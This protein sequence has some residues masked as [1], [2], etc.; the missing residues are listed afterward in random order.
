MSLYTVPLDVLLWAFLAAYLVHIID[1]TLVGEGF[2]KIVQRWFWPQYH[3][4]MFFWFNVACILLVAACNALYDFLGGHWVIAALLWPFGFA[5][6][7]VTLH[8][9]WSI[10][11]GE[12]FS[13][14][15]TSPLYWI[16]VYFIYRYGYLGGQIE[17][18]DFLWGM[19][20]GTILI[21]G[22]LTFA[23]TYIFPALFRQKHGEN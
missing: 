13:G 4:R 2:T 5:V 1:E 19:A 15:L 17:R 8:L 12:Y 21:G 14:L 20:A 16:S 7:G 22:F 3:L 11:R 23:P 10:R 18:S 9:W 6:H